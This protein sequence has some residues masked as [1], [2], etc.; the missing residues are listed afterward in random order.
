MTNSVK[1]LA[2]AVRLLPP[3]QQADLI[4]ELV[5]GLGV[6]DTAWN[7][8]WAAEA[9]HRWAA[10]VASGHAGHAAEDV[11]SDIAAHLSKRRR[12]S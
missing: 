12:T 5:I 7:A 3:E 9:D 6:S 8:A 2:I 1:A 11:L 10:H 4:D